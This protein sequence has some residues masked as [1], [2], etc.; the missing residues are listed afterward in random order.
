MAKGIAVGS[1]DRFGEAW[2]VA[3]G[4]PA[5]VD[6]IGDNV[7]RFPST[8]YIAAGDAADV[9]S[10]RTYSLQDLAKPTTRLHLCQRQGGYQSRGDALLRRD[11]CVGGSAED[12]RFPAFGS[13]GPH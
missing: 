4:F 3:E 11:T 6:V 13:D 12:L 1:G 10:A 5:D 9:G 8:L 2:I 7:G